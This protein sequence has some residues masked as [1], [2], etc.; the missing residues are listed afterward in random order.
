MYKKELYLYGQGEVKKATVR[1]YTKIDIAELINIQK[2][3]F[4]PPFPS[5][6]WWNEEQL[7]N[8]I[9]L[10]Q[11]GAL[12]V[13]IDGVLAGSMTC[14]CVS[15]NENEPNHTWEEITDNG[16]IRTHN[17]KGNTLYVVDICVRPSFRELQLGKVLMQAMYEVV[18]H[19]NL[20]R[21]LG[22][23]R[24]PGYHKKADELSPEAYIEKV[25]NGELKD[26]VISFLLKS[27]RTPH[28]LIKNY[29]DDEESLNY[30]LLMEWKN[31]FK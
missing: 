17:P 11:D 20:D 13:E 18:V 8:H 3:S 12:C 22:G 1:N 26:P 30:G 16:Y 4:P 29:L 23:G 28:T 27:G 31:P 9:K 10:F 5:E 6:L 24:M 19:L 15:F 14:L 2:E 25:I 7:T 21:L